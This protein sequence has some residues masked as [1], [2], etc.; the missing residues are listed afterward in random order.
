MQIPRQLLAMWPPSSL[1]NIIFPPEILLQALIGPVIA[2]GT[3]KQSL[4]KIAKS[5]S[6]WFI[7]NILPDGEWVISGIYFIITRRELPWLSGFC[8][9]PTLDLYFIMKEKWKEENALKHKKMVWEG[10]IS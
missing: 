6:T 4:L 3:I 9:P 1:S 10:K 5:R 8:I 2:F 7:R